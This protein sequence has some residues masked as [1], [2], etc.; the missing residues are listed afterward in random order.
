MFHLVSPLNRFDTSPLQFFNIRW[1]R[2]NINLIFSTYLDYK[3]VNQGRVDSNHLLIQILSNIAIKFDGD[4]IGYMISVEQ[5]S[6]RIAGTLGLT[7]ATVRGDLFK[8]K[9]IFYKGMNEVITVSRNDSELLDLWWDWRAATPVTVHSHPITDVKLFDPIVKDTPDFKSKGYA[10]INIDIPL[11]AGQYVMFR[12]NYPD[13]TVEQYISQIVIPGMMKS[14]MDIVLFNKVCHGLGVMDE[15]TVKTNLPFAQQE[16]NTPADKL[17]EDIVKGILSRPLT[18][19]QILSSI[20]TLLSDSTALMALKIPDIMVTQQS[21]WA[22]HSQSVDKVNLV[23]EVAKR[24]NHYDRMLQLLVKI[25]RNNI[26][27]IQ[28]GWYRNGL[29]T[30]TTRYLMDRWETVLSRIPEQVYESLESK[31]FDYEY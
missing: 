22:I 1:L 21:L 20:P 28:E 23:L 25:R 13:G 9:G 17:S 2:E 30:N 16:F 15:L 10:F 31:L 18:P 24:R 14:H 11:L 8:N 12:S 29:N 6:R 5:N 7:S 4:L 19:T 3:R 26:R 27:L